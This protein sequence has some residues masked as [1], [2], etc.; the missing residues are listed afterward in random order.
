MRS[1]HIF[2]DMYVP[3]DMRLSKDENNA[4]GSTDTAGHTH[5]VAPRHMRMFVSYAQHAKGG[6]WEAERK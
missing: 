4:P 2:I 3:P 6:V 5:S 1:N